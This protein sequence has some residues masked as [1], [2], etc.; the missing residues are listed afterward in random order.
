M[1]PMFRLLLAQNM[2]EVMSVYFVHFKSGIIII[3]VIIIIIIIIL[4]L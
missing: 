4:L 1:T 3:I 2:F